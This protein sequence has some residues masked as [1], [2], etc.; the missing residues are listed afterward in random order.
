MQQRVLSK[1]YMLL[2]WMEMNGQ[3]YFH[4]Y[5]GCSF[6]AFNAFILIVWQFWNLETHWPLR[7]QLCRVCHRPKLGGTMDFPGCYYD[8]LLFDVSKAGWKWIMFS[9][10]NSVNV[11]D[12]WDIQVTCRGHS[13]NNEIF[14]CYLALFR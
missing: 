10:G 7:F 5:S 13:E 9:F 3:R 4:I 8:R 1:G 14:L 12:S 6:L 11:C 2:T